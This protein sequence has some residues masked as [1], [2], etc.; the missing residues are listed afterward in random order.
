M[1]NCNNAKTGYN[2]PRVHPQF[3]CIT[4]KCADEPSFK[5][6]NIMYEG[7]PCNLTQYKRLTNIK[8]GQAYNNKRR[9]DECCILPPL[10]IWI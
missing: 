7:L 10:V 2:N 4:H 1:G 3:R 5:S 6:P 8:H 9:Q